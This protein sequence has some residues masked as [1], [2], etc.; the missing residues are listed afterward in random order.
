L[1]L[2]KRINTSWSQGTPAN[3]G[4]GITDLIV[5]PEVV[6]QIRGMAFNP[7][8]DKGID[9]T[10]GNV[11]VGDDVNVG[12]GG[13]LPAHD[14]LRE[15]LWSGAGLPDFYG[16]SLL[17]LNEMGVGQRYND[18]FKAVASG[19]NSGFDKATD[20]I[21]LGIDRDRESLI[22]AV[23]VD[24]DFGSEMQLLADDQYSV[25]QSRIGYYGALEEGRMI[26]DDRALTGV[27]ICNADAAGANAGC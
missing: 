24:A 4:R 13:V 25:R 19:T 16:I 15:A 9:S 26:L 11:Q 12:G 27:K 3:R 22:R 1:T 2:A 14:S 7:V 20:E 10:H 21:C 8:N 18:V 17:E 5:S 6:G 23:A